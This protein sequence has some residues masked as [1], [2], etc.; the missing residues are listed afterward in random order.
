MQNFESQ[1]FET[2]LI[3]AGIGGWFGMEKK[4]TLARA[5]EFSGLSTRTLSRYLKGSSSPPPP[6]IK[7]LKIRA[8]GYIPQDG[9][10]AG[11]HIRPDGKMHSPNG[12]AFTP[13]RLEQLWIE[14]S[15]K[16]YL[17]TKI[18]HLERKIENLKSI[19][20][21]DR[22]EAMIKMANDLLE[23]AGEANMSE[24]SNTA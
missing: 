18:K 22:K 21:H 24:I 23:L 13:Q 4:E 17:N 14:L 10:W 19:G 2:M 16:N 15:R 5:S 6:L 11:Y 9:E 20:I 8:A 12:E 7:L 1:S 3:L